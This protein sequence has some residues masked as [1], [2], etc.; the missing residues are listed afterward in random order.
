MYHHAMT[1][2]LAVQYSYYLYIFMSGKW[3][4]TTPQQSEYRWEVAV[5]SDHCGVFLAT[6]GIVNHNDNEVV[7]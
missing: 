2:I 1:A 6:T 7:F 5:L 4:A 3:A